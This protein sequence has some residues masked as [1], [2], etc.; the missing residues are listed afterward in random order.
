MVQPRRQRR[1][2]LGVAALASVV[3][4][5]AAVTAGADSGAS[6]AAT[7]PGFSTQPVQQGE[8]APDDP[9]GRGRDCPE[10]GGDAGGGGG[11]GQSQDGTPSATPE[12]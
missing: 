4:L 6:G 7:E 12:V 1:M 10:R 3:A 9:R 5:G 11:G 8:A 2:G